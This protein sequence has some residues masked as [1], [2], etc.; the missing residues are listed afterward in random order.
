MPRKNPLPK[1][2][3]R[4]REELIAQAT[5]NLKPGQSYKRYSNSAKL[6]ARIIVEKGGTWEEASKVSGVPVKNLKETST[7]HNWATPR[8]VA[9]KMREIIDS[10]N[11][12]LMDIPAEVLPVTFQQEV[13]SVTLP[14][15][16][17]AR[18]LTVIPPK[19]IG[20]GD[21]I[22]CDSGLDTD[23]EYDPDTELVAAPMQGILQV[24]PQ[25][26]HN[27]KQQHRNADAM[28]S[29]E[30]VRSLAYR[31][32]IT[33]ALYKLSQYANALVDNNPGVA[34]TMINHIQKLDAIASKRF[35]LDD[36]K[37][38]ETGE[39]LKNISKADVDDLFA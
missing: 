16:P 17:E 14:A 30:A 33:N 35:K 19:S 12:N 25:K 5:S 29:T 28:V 24:L 3:K 23:V 1:K 26:F 21:Y 36:S 32:N 22:P 13:D 38:N 34:L 39:A 7:K 6:K 4:T 20:K 10:G 37:T 11:P 31:E 9:T 2:P 18:T 15:R 8:R 27:Y